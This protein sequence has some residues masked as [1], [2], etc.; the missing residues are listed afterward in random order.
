MK[1]QVKVQHLAVVLLQRMLVRLGISLATMV[2]NLSAHK[3]GWDE[4]WKEFSDWADKGQ[5]L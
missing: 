3:K 1:R 5:R 4:R 2:A